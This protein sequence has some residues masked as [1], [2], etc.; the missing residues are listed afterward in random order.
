MNPN[1]DPDLD[2]KLA[3][4]AFFVLKF[5]PNLI[6]KHKKAAFPQLCDLAMNKV[7]NNF[8][9][10]WSGSIGKRHGSVDPSLY[11]NVT[12]QQRWLQLLENVKYCMYNCMKLPYFV[13]KKRLLFRDFV[14]IQ[15]ISIGSGS[16]QKFLDP[17]PQHR[18]KQLTNSKVPYGVMNLIPEL[19]VRFRIANNCT[20]TGWGDGIFLKT[21]A[22]LS[23]TKA[24]RN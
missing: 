10:F 19:A 6:F 15:N 11:Q 9:V 18:L 22:P 4:T 13:P 2:Q 8:A 14:R 7:C 5:L 16:S 24:F 23:L 1:P 3:K 20:L 17:N 21:S 12:D